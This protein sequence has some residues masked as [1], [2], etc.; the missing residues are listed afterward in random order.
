[1]K[2]LAEFH[3][4]LQDPF[5]YGRG[6]KARG[7][8]VVGY[9]CSYAPEEMIHAAG[10]HPFRLFG[11][12]GG[13]HLADAHFQ[14]YCCSLVR[15]ALEGALSGRLDFL[16]GAV[17]PHTC[18]SIQRLSD[19]WRMNVK[20]PFHIDAV[21]PVKLDTDSARVYMADV[22]RRFRSE[23]GAALG[24]EI[25]DE[26]LRGSLGTFNRIRGHLRR[27]YELKA[28]DAGAIRGS[29]LSTVLRASMIMDRE[30]LL[31][32]LPPL[33]AAVEGRTGQ[34]AQAGK[35]LV[36]AGGVCSHPDI[37]RIVED[38]GGV[39]VWDDLCTGSR[40]FEGLAE[41]GDDPVASLARRYAWRPPCPAKHSGLFAR[42]EHLVE[43]V[44]ERKARGVVFFFLKFC[45]L[46][47]FDYSHLTEALDREGIPSMMLEVEETLPSEGQLQT[48]FETFIEMIRD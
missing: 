41:A 3:E 5:A 37:Y 10:A 23:L 33:V 22:L 31:E 4:I 44:R 40:Y 9:F 46:H 20:G 36:M 12:G 39:V 21:L 27:L 35:P 19:I 42:A 47:A 15:G 29:D 2:E 26:A 32:A 1:M 30:R 8:R 14:S 38:A 16:D 13:I 24:A 6:L 17:F 43:I 11:A 25:S 34:G 45:D 28:E 7:R 48:R 18:D